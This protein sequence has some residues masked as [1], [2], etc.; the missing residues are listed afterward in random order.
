MT[1][2]NHLRPFDVPANPL[3]GTTNI[4][5]LLTPREAAMAL[6]ISERS[7]W[8]LTRRGVIRRVRLG[9][10]VRYSLDDLRSFI[11]VQR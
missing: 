8:D 7:L 10:S 6:A 1:D 2:T 4:R 9:R 11:D 3:S 5:L